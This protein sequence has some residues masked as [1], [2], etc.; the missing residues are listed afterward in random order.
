MWI[1]QHFLSEGPGTECSLFHPRDHSE[2]VS[3]ASRNGTQSLPEIN[4]LG[5]TLSLQD[6]VISERLSCSC[7]V[8]YLQHLTEDFEYSSIG[9]MR[10]KG[11]ERWIKR[12]DG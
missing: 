12:I 5:Q 8:L 3:P 2:V 9:W 1:S 6:E 4:L 10:D 11:M 7:S